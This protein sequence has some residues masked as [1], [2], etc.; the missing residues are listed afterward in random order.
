[1]LDELNQAHI[2]YLMKPPSFPIDDN[3]EQNLFRD[4]E[5]MEPVEFQNKTFQQHL[6]NLPWEDSLLTKTIERRLINGKH[7][8]FCR[9]HNDTLALVGFVW[10][11]AFVVFRLYLQ[12]VCTSTCQQKKKKNNLGLAKYLYLHY[13][14]GIILSLESGLVGLENL[15]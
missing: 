12:F 8:T 4:L 6:E 10:T 2:A 14:I 7:M 15:N 1:M 13:Y 11:V 5:I 3:K 9:L